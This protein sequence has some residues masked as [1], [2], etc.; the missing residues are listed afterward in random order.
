V[1]VR[2]RDGLD[3]SRQRARLHE[4]LAAP[5]SVLVFA[6]VASPV[7]IAVD[8]N[9]NMAA[10]ALSGIALIALFYAGWQVSVLLGESAFAFAAA[11]PWLTL[12]A[13]S[14]LGLA[15]LARSPR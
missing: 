9:R 7:G 4:R 13:F 2:R 15:L 6:L 5:L 8:R 11:G 10:P 14:L 3:A 1:D 12:V